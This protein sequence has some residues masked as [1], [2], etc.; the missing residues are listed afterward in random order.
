MS[1]ISALGNLSQENYKF[2]A[3]LGYSKANQ[4]E[5]NSEAGCRWLTPV[6]LATQNTSQKRAGGMAKGIERKTERK[7]RERERINTG[8]CTCW[9][10]FYH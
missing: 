6:I 2:K 7:E 10:A 9:Q 4:K 5:K 8:P 3:R 1:V